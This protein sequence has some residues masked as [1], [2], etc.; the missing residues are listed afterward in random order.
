MKLVLLVLYILTLQT[1]GAQSAGLDD[2]KLTLSER[3]KLM[4]SKASTYGEYKVV[5]ELDLDLFYKTLRDSLQATKTGLINSNKS[6]TALQVKVDSLE[7]TIQQKE[8][9]VQDILYDST[10]ITV[11]GI[12]FSK[13]FF[14]GLVAIL[15]AGMIA[16]LVIVIGRMRVIQHAFKEKSALAAEI[17]SEYASYKLKAMEKQTKLARD[18]QTE[19]NRPGR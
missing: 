2:P 1:L 3:Y 17:A 7:A 16:G 4:K 10:H 19:L 5:K 13:A 11:L 14:I 18:L 12:N 15:I 9:S 8:A 6:I